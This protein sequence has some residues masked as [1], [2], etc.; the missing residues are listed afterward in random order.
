[1]TARFR[2]A[3]RRLPH[4]NEGALYDM[5]EGAERKIAK[6]ENRNRTA[7]SPETPAAEGVHPDSIALQASPVEGRLSCPRW[8]KPRC[9]S[10]S[11]DLLLG[12]AVRT[13][14][15]F[16]ANMVANRLF[17][18]GAEGAVAGACAAGAETTGSGGHSSI[19]A[20]TGSSSIGLGL[21]ASGVA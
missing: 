3:L 20:A 1:M 2:I 7:N 17:L 5:L 16:G 18:R 10:R 8:S 11:S 19:R 9:S 15:G 14:R 6:A 13:G 21:G 4:L 12:R